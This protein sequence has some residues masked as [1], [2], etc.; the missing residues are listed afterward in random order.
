MSVVMALV[1]ML[2]S[3]VVVL[4]VEKAHLWNRKPH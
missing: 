1:T 4:I 2:V 3:A